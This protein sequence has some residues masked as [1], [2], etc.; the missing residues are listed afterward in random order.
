[1]L[2]PVFNLKN[3]FYKR[4]RPDKPPAVFINKNIKKLKN[5]KLKKIVNKKI[6]KKKDQIFNKI[7]KLRI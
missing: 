7:K 1:M 3:N 2:K 6:L 5:F 4:F